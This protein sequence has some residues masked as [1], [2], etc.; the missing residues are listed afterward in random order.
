MRYII[1]GAGAIGGTI[2][3]RLFQHGH[4]VIL[5]ARGAH[6]ET[7]K[8]NG[9]T[10]KTP[11]ESVQLPIPCFGRP[12]EIEFQPQD[13]VF[14]AMKTQHTL[15]AL[16]DLRNAA[17]EDI[18]VICA[19]NGV[20]NER[21]A[22]RRFSRVYAMVVML[23]ASHMEPGVVQSESKTTTGL[24]DTGCFPSGTD[25]VIEEVIET[26]SAS[27]FSSLADPKVMRYKYAKL[28]NN[29]N[30]ALQALCGAGAEGR[31]ISRMIT[32][33]ALACYEAAG[34]DC[35]SR[36]EFASRRGDL[37]QVGTI[38]GQPRAGSSSWQSIARGTGS[39]EADYLNGEIV[40]L[41]R[42][43]NVPTPAN[44][45]LQRLANKLA[46][47]GAKPGS[48]TLDEIKKQIIEAGGAF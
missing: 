31:D 43:H 40:L 39:I 4:E 26:L 47:E 19:Q 41:G 15:G 23:P 37:I 8:K 38:E 14:L 17:G 34:I 3:A 13:A 25:P 18:P 16:D 42:M 35:A 21:L 2:G 10:F 44:K 7:I 45:V 48:Y 12:S 6:L 20:A 24:L 11:L 5:I 28:L 1:Y 9:L 29:L 30:N 36:D 33:E 22:L 27:N 32:H 46:R